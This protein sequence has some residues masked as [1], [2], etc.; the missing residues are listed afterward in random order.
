[1]GP[2]PN[3]FQSIFEY[4]AN[5]DQIDIYYVTFPQGYTGE[6]FKAREGRKFNKE[7][8]SEIELSILSK[9]CEAFK[10]TSTNNIIEISHL[11]NAW[12]KNEQEKEVISYNFAFDLSQI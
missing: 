8:F 9:V 3:N 6:Q 11:E 1:M 5:K 7:L 12:K 4:L 10:S 2:V